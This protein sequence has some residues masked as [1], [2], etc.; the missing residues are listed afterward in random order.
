MAFSQ[1][2]RQPFD[3]QL[4]VWVGR[5]KGEVVKSFYCK[6]GAMNDAVKKEILLL[7]NG[8]LF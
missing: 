7:Y 6:D 5:W 2:R 4:P 1:G 3:R 8:M